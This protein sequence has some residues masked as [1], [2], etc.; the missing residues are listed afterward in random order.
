M[1]K[2]LFNREGDYRLILEN[3]ND[4]VSIIGTR[5]PFEFEYINE[6]LWQ[7]SLNYFPE[8]LIGKSFLKIVHKNFT[9]Q[10]IKIL[11]DGNKNKNF[12]TE[13]RILSK[14]G[15]LVWFNLKKEIF[16]D[17][18][19]K[20][21]NLVILKEISQFKQ[22]KAQ[23][24]NEEKNLNVLTKSIPEIKFWRLFTP[25]KYEEALMRSYEI[26]EL[27]INSIPQYI[28]WKDN[29]L[30]YLGCN[31]NYTSLV[32]IN[33]P[34][35]IIGKKNDDI[36]SD[37][38]K[39]NTL[40]QKEREILNEGVPSYHKV[41]KWR[42]SDGTELI[43]DINRVPLKDSEGR[44]VGILTT[45]QDITEKIEKDKKLIESEQ[46]YRN[47]IETSSVGILEVDLTDD[48]ISYIN[49]KLV[50]ILGFQGK[51][52]VSKSEIKKYI[53]LGKLK[54]QVQ[55]NG[56]RELE[57]RI[58][59]CKR[60]LKWISG[61]YVNHYNSEGKLVTLRFWLEDITERKKYEDLITELNI[62]F[63]N[64]GTNIQENIKAL[65]NTCKKLLNANSVAYVS[66]YK[67]GKEEFFQL[68]STEDEKFSLDRQD[69]EDQL[70]LSKFFKKEHDFLQYYDLN[71][72]SKTKYSKTD[73]FIK[74]NQ[75]KCAIGKKIISDDTFNSII[76]CFSEDIIEN[77][78]QNQLVLFLIADAIE[79]EQKRWEMTQH[80]RKQNIRLQEMDNLKT[81]LFSRV[82]H[83]LKTP[84]ISIK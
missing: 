78:P 41:E 40:N 59:D 46:K 19:G 33:S 66:K 35:R 68:L 70:F 71:K 58:Y 14:N 48:T 15:L 2:E 13:V 34:E 24:K 25:K 61:K 18:K 6:S 72:I 31:S 16:T 8:D 20:K 7:S 49:P 56:K 3:I 38:E 76:C 5:F 52:K 11:E 32:G 67:K 82:S 64:F 43:I 55:S 79:I 69:F 1:S 73:P 45:F 23:V 75:Y 36:F 28:F 51:E 44:I 42:N 57:F 65:L 74:N 54:K 4:L 81:E 84:L 17:H 83:E 29:D 12:R 50:E 53:P 63:L 47:L 27:V 9:Q 26:L 10:I 77:A 39:V 80:L 30:N 21:K 60:N 62:N 37:N 22:L